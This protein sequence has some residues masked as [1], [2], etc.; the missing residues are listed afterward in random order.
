MCPVYR[1]VLISGYPIRGF[2]CS[3]LLRVLQVTKLVFGNV[4]LFFFR[5]VRTVE[6]DEGIPVERYAHTSSLNHATCDLLTF[7]VCQSK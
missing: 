3:D 7:V 4:P 1:G 6:E 2:H 5:R